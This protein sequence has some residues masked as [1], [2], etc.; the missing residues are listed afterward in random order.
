[1]KKNIKKEN[2][3]NYINLLAIINKFLY[4]SCETILDE[5]IEEFFEEYAKEYENPEEFLNNL[6]PLLNQSQRVVY[7]SGTLVD[8]EFINFIND[9]SEI[10]LEERKK[11]IKKDNIELLIPL[12]AYYSNNEYFTTLYV[13]D[14]F[15]IKTKRRKKTELELQ[16]ELD[17]AVKTENYELAVKIREKIKKIKK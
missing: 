4:F 5:D 3:E 8:V 11:L 17:E 13:V 15:K 10:S 2:N 12:I 6:S 7:L 9:L 1:M 16:S 14:I